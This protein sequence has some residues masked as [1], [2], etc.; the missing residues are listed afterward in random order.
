VSEDGAAASGSM[1][2]SGVP[3]QLAVRRL[4]PELLDDWLHFFD[5]EAFADNPDWAGCYCYWFHADAAEKAWDARTAEENR[6]ASAS[7]IRAGRLSGYLAYLDGRMVGWCQAAPRTR[8]PNLAKDPALV[9]EDVDRVGAIV[10]FLVAAGARRRGVAGALLD[11][12]CDGFRAEGLW[13]AEA[14]P[15]KAAQGDAHNYHGPLALYLRAGFEPYR[16]VDGIIMVRRPLMLVQT[17]G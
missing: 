2:P 16:E 9:V 13:T 11:A 12:A 6:A 7:L 5:G 1:L 8:I 3:P 10:C 17:G 15:V 14:Y 4:T